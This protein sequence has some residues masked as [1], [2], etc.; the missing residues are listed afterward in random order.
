MG[1]RTIDFEG[2]TTDQVLAMPSR[3]LESLVFFGEP[4]SFRAGTATILGQFR[5]S[6]DR[7]LLELAQIEGGGEGVLPALSALAER[8]ARREGLSK[9]EW[10]VHAIT[11]AHPNLK[12][13][14]VLKSK[15]FKIEEVTGIGEAYHLIKNLEQRS[16]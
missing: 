4:I 14:R 13:R 16:I 3:D 8:Y 7:L 2:M 9:I 15:G 6:G 5:R 11:C 1:A 10:I 12:L